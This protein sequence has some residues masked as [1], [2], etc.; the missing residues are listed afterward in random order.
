VSSQLTFNL[1]LGIAIARL[2]GQA[3]KTEYD[4]GAFDIFG[5]S[6]SYYSRSEWG[7]AVTHVTRA[8]VTTWSIVFAAILAQTLKAVAT[9]QVER[10]IRLG[11]ATNIS[12][13]CNELTGL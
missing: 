5:Y 8:A 2:K 10:G 11:V 6:L 12:L 4:Y 7:F 3:T 13:S 9:Y 1:G